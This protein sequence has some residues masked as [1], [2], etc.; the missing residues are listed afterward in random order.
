MVKSRKNKIVWFLI[1]FVVFIAM[2]INL[3]PLLWMLLGSF[4]HNMEIIDPNKILSLN[5]TLDNYR[6]I[7]NSGGFVKPL[8]NS[9]CLTGIST[10]ASLMIGLPAAYSF[11]RF[12]MQ[13]AS[14]MV[15]IIRMIPNMAFMLPWFIMFR[16]MGIVKTHFGL[17]LAFTVSSLPL[18][19]WIMMPCF[20]A[21]PEDIMESA[22]V[23]GASEFRT[24][25][26]II[27]PI[28]A[29]SIMTTA[30]MTIIGV[31]NNFLFVMV[32]GDASQ[33]T[34]PMQLMNFIGESNTEWGKLLAGAA[35]V[36]SPIIIISI[37][38]QKYIVNGVT[39]GATK[40]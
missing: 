6:K 4:K 30:I 11:A 10:V 1:C 2:A 39:A 12:K 8:L 38:M 19:V 20:E 24:F 36:T 13:K 16:T 18:I 26:K 27:I 40:G 5:F 37:V 7:L 3:F 15:L 33:R 22:R 32:L 25:C 34:L 14:Q 28:A 23:D 21:I 9:V 29:P 35:V 31:W 17:I